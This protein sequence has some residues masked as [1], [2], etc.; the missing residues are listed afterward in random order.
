[1]HTSFQ[2]SKLLVQALVVFVLLVST[3]GVSGALA[4]PV[5]PGYEYYVVGSPNNVTRT[6]TFGELLMG[7]GTDVD[8]A[9]QWMINKSGGGDFVVIRATGTDAYNPYIFGLGTVDSVETIIITSRTSANDPFVVNKIRNAEAL[10]IAGGDQY[11][12]VNFW[13]GTPVE[14]AIHYLVTRNVPIG[15]TSAGLAVMGEFL[16]SAANGTV[17][18]TTALGNPYNSK[19][20]LDRDFLVLPNLGGLITDS[21][22]VTRDR[23]G[24]LVAFLA[25]IVKDGWATSAKGVGI[26]EMTALAVEA[27]GT[28][29]VLGSG[30]AYFL[31]T[32][33]APEVCLAKKALTYRNLSVYRVSG[34]ATFNLSTWVGSG[35]IA[36][37]LTAE[38]GVLTSTQAG[39]GIY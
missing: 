37:I 10:F 9:F 4:A 26:D 27:N 36:Y 12:Y 8:A 31:R 22:F 1:M 33:G 29:T 6:T 21:H 2:R 24:R 15:G 39:G 13:K 38:N 19:V 25:R 34:T 35:G 3:G 20:A 32:P 30:A 18:S 7:G 14:D 17:D 16:F 23:M 5:K 28:A 11:D